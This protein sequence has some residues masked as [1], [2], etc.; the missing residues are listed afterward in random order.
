MKQLKNHIPTEV[1]AMHALVSERASR[2]L[3]LCTVFLALLA[4]WALPF[5][6]PPVRYDTVNAIFDAEWSLYAK[7][8]AEC[9]GGGVSCYYTL[10]KVGEISSSP[11]SGSALVLLTYGGDYPNKGPREDYPNYKHFVIGNQAVYVVAG[12]APPD[13]IHWSEHRELFTKRSLS[14]TEGTCL[15]IRELLFAERVVGRKRQILE[16]SDL[17]LMA[18][19]ADQSVLRVALTDPKLGRFYTTKELQS[20]TSGGPFYYGEDG[21]GSDVD[22]CV[23]ADCFRNNLF[24][25]FRPDGTFLVYHYA[26]DLDLTKLRYLGANALSS[27]AFTP[28]SKVTCAGYTLAQ[29]TVVPPNTLPRSELRPLAVS[30][31]YGDTVYCLRKGSKFDSVYSEYKQVMPKWSE[32]SGGSSG[33]VDSSQFYNEIQFLFWRDPFGRLV[34]YKNPRLNPPSAC[35]PIIYLYP[36][37][38]QSVSIELGEGVKVTK[39]A[40]QYRSGW[41]VTASPNGELID[42][43][44]GRKY[45]NLFWEGRNSLLPEFESGFCVARSEV[46]TFFRGKLAYLGLNQQEIADFLKAWENEFQ[47]SAFYHIWFVPREIIDLYAPL[48]V[49]PPPETTIRIMFDYVK[50]DKKKSIEPQTLH[51]GPQRKGFTLVEWGGMKRLSNMTVG[52]IAVTEE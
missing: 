14:V 27:T 20:N 48:R 16:L 43:S 40:P 10:W 22:N 6:E 39:A 12:T 23:D 34:V 8:T 41:T 21:F 36:T 2:R 7:D 49:A 15:V 26:P 52:N 17:P 24:Y 38:K 9:Y 46:Q 3:G 37:V 5:A 19:R 4:Y 31:E 45:R 28:A 18:G 30:G 47:N 35:E 51:R 29:I 13:Y 25:Y 11:F 1:V 50:L 44:T 42:Q 32:W 33:L